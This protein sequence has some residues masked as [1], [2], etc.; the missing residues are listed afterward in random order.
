MLYIRKH[1][2]SLMSTFEII[3]ENQYR[4]YQR[5]ARGQPCHKVIVTNGRIYFHV[6]EGIICL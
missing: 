5:I 2:Q 1:Y 3:T 4:V 6:A